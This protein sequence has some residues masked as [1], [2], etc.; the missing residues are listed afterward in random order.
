MKKFGL[1]LLTGALTISL[2]A[3]GGTDEEANT[4]A[5]NEE[6]AEASSEPAVAEFTI[7]ATNWEFTSD[8]ELTIQKGTKV[9]LNLVNKEG[10]H[11]ISNDELG[12][13]L[14]ADT[15]FE[16]TA[17]KTGEYTLIC[18]TICGSTEDHDEMVITLNIVD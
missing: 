17:E 18:S 10:F 7:T 6:I 16:F 5:G 12:L 11:T 1:F 2:A 8:K 4:S 13:D 3:C 15:P 9:K 14:K